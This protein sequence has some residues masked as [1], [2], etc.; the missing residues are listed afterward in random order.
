M[1]LPHA[2]IDVEVHD[3]LSALIQSEDIDLID[4]MEIQRTSFPTLVKMQ[5]HYQQHL[6]YLLYYIFSIARK[7]FTLKNAASQTQHFRSSLPSSVTMIG[8]YI[9]KHQV[10]QFSHGRIHKINV[11]VIVIYYN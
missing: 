4:I 10:S 11:S 3:Y 8:M 6:Y 9:V 5:S 7:C 1:L 2:T